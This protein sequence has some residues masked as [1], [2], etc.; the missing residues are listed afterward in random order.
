MVVVVVQQVLGCVATC[1]WPCCEP[2]S[3]H[4]CVKVLP[5][6][7][8]K[9]V[10]F[11]GDDTWDGLFPQAFYRAYFFPSF[12]VKDLHTVDDGILQNL[13]QTGE[14]LLSWVGGLGLELNRVEE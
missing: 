5:S 7:S 8:G 4:T 10:V 13:Y 6:L 11:M 14:H 3:F 12:N 1:W 9:K 2:T